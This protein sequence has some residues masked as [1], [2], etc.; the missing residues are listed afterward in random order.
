MVADRRIEPKRPGAPRD[1]RS[2]R[3]AVA[4]GEQGHFVTH[5]DERVRQ[6]RDDALGAAIEFGRNGFHQRRDL[7]NPHR[8]S[9]FFGWLTLGREICFICLTGCGISAPM[10]RGQCR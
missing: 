10:H 6:I 5:G 3:R 2:R 7:S 4:A 1:E 9:G 8:P